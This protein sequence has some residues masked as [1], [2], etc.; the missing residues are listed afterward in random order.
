MIDLDERSRA[1]EIYTAEE[2]GRMAHNRFMEDFQEDRLWE[3]E[4]AFDFEPDP[5][6]MLSYFYHEERVLEIIEEQD[7][8]RF[9]LL[10]E[11]LVQMDGLRKLEGVLVI[12]ATNRYNILD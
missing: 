2:T 3:Y 10:I 1:S 7:L 9:S 11:F 8:L 4:R 5:S 6:A 12:G